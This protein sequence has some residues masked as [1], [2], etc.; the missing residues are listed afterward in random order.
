MLHQHRSDDFVL[1]ILKLVALFQYHP[2]HLPLKDFLTINYYFSSNCSNQIVHVVINES[3]RFV[4][5]EINFSRYNPGFIS[6]NIGFF[7]FG[8][9]VLCP[10]LCIHVCVWNI[11]CSWKEMFDF[12]V[13]HSLLAEVA[14]FIN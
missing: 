6:M 7:L 1:L 10:V 2:F 14:V 9:V 8:L 3:L 11:I 5:S 13:H 4:S 12:L